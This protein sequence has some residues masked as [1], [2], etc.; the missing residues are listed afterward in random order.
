MIISK[1]ITL[2]IIKLNDFWN[3]YIIIYDDYDWTLWFLKII[4]SVLGW[5]LYLFV[6]WVLRVLKL[7]INGLSN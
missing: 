6:W 3:L 7:A 5:L 1:S 4:R 2:A